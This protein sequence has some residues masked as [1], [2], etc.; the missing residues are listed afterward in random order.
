MIKYIYIIFLFILL[1]SFLFIEKDFYVKDKIVLGAS[2]PKTGIMKEWGRSVEIG[3]NAYFKYINEKN[4]LLPNKKIKFLTLDDKYE[5]DLTYKNTNKFLK[6][7]NLFALYAYVGTPTVKRVLP[8]LEKNSLPFIA[9]FTGASF[10]RDKENKNIINFRSSYQKEIEK[11]VNYLIEKKNISK[12]AVFYQNDDYGEE[13]YISLIKVLD[14][15]HLKLTGEGT[16]KRN[17]LSIRHAFS[18]IK[19]SKPEAIIM[20][21][22]YKANSLFIK[23]AKQDETLKNAIFCNISFGD[24]NEMIKELNFKTNN[25]LFSQVVPSYDNYNIDVIR[26]YKYLMKKYYPNE[27]LGFISLESFLAAKIVVQAIQNVKGRLCR[28]KFMK[29]LKLLFKNNKRKTILLNKDKV[30]LFE[31]K[32]SEFQEIIYETKE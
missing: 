25:I 15:K 6:T 14:K 17:T 20:I 3:S 31:Y 16:Y 11:T 26:E 30:Y 4:N 10:L 22:A 21:G 13:G 12:F 8:I 27:S 24:A 9:P 7:K 2:F 18:E 19:D 32:N 29:E 1:A 5:P 28:N 23:K